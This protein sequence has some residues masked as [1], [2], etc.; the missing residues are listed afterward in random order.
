VLLPREQPHL[1][2]SPSARPILSNT[3][4]LGVFDARYCGGA[5]AEVSPTEREYDEASRLGVRRIV[6]VDETKTNTGSCDPVNDP[7]NDAVSQ[8]VLKAIRNHPGIRRNVIAQIAGVSEATIKRRLKGL[9]RF[10]RFRGA[11]KTGGYWV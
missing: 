10:V 3:R 1:H 5:D 6:L 7:V 8:L 2:L 4:L 11:P 9:T